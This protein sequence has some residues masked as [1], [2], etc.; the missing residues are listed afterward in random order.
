M[1]EPAQALTD[2]TPCCCCAPISPGSAAELVPASACILG[3]EGGEG[4]GRGER[5]GGESG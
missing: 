5:K 2:K 1:V 3:R 4:R